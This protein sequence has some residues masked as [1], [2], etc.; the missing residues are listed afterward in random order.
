MKGKQV[1]NNVGGKKLS[2]V[3]KEKTQYSV[4]LFQHEMIGFLK[5]QNDDN[6]VDQWRG[7]KVFTIDKQ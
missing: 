2:S 1:N 4:S 7:D 5:K 6:D 3:K